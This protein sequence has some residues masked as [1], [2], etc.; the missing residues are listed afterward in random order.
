MRKVDNILPSILYL[1][2]FTCVLG[3]IVYSISNIESIKSLNINKRIIGERVLREYQLKKGV[4]FI[5]LD[6]RSKDLASKIVRSNNNIILIADFDDGQW[7]KVI[8]RSSK[9]RI[10]FNNFTLK[11]NKGYLVV[12]DKDTQLILEGRKREKDIK[13]DFDNGWNLIGAVNYG[14]STNL[15]S[16][17]EEKGV[18]VLGVA[19]WSNS[20]GTFLNLKYSDTQMFG[21]D[22]NIDIQDGVFIKVENK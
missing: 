21:E 18:D 4:N 12:V 17:I 14:T 15:I 13:Y 11:E 9:N 8:K 2:L 6:F 19:N 3:L 10:F 5:G 1:L 20:L 7:D 22:F 16:K